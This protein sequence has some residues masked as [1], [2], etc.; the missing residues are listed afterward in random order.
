[1]ALLPTADYQ[2]P[3]GSGLPGNISVLTPKGNIVS[4]LGGISQFT[5]NSDAGPGPTVTLVA[6]TPGV[7]ATSAQGNI[8]LG[9]GGALGGAV[10]VKATGNITGL[11]VSRQDTTVTANQNINV[12]VLSGGKAT[13]NAGGNLSGTLIAVNGIDASGG[14]I[15]ATMLSDSVSDNGGSSQS[16]LGTATASAAA[17]S[18]AGTANA[19]NQQQVATNDQSGDDKKKKPLPQV[20]R[21]KR[22]TVL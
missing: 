16:T 21:V 22:V 5:V 20:R 3:G 2:I 8:N 1:M 7:T 10:N 18:A 11:I 4:T 13:V 15:T 14:D 9:Q 6:G 17:D 19:Q 12:T